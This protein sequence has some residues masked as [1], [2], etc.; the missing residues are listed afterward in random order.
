MSANYNWSDAIAICFSDNHIREFSYDFVG[1]YLNGQK[2]IFLQLDV[3]SGVNK[4][5]WQIFD[6][7]EKTLELKQIQVVY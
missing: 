1:L 2:F 3:S 4:K 5:T 6:S 7:T